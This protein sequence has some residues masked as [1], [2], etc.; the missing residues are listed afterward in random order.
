M[1]YC[2]TQFN[3]IKIN[4]ETPKFLQQNMHM[5]SNE[6]QGFDPKNNFILTNL[7]SVGFQELELFDLTL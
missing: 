3:N 4:Y 1:Y 7:N 5:V 2:D 6:H